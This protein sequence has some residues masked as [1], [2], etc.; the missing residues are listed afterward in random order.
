[1][2][3]GRLLL[4]PSP[5]LLLDR[6]RDLF[7]ALPLPP[8]W[9]LPLPPVLWCDLPPLGAPRPGRCDRLPSSPLGSCSFSIL[10]MV[11]PVVLLCRVSSACL[12][13]SSSTRCG[14]SG[15]EALSVAGRS[16]ACFSDVMLAFSRA[17]SARRSS[18][19]FRLAMSSGGSCEPSK[20]RP[21]PGPMPV[22][23]P[24]LV[25]ALTNFFTSVVGSVAGAV[26]TTCVLAW[27]FPPASL[28]I[29]LLF[30]GLGGLC[31][32]GGELDEQDVPV[33]ELEL[34]ADGFGGLDELDGP[35]EELDWEAV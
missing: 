16:L 8:R 17:C 6:L 4:L 20:P 2:P 12:S 34:D 23:L 35:M 25:G 24:D 19:A 1:L 29:L 9:P 7:A 33:E 18:R 27:P 3:C 28:G 13:L 5:C 22:L 15:C 11:K 30:V 14:E 10:R 32:S 26:R 21:Y 31:G